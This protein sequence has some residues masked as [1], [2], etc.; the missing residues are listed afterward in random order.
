MLQVLEGIG[1]RER[2]ASCNIQSFIHHNFER[3]SSIP[4]FHSAHSIPSLCGTH[5]H[6]SST[7]PPN[8]LERT[9][10]NTVP[11]YSDPSVRPS[12]RSE[13]CSPSLTHFTTLP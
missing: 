7:H 11:E 4:D 5:F 8:V 12:P 6:T 9:G 2:E 3:G 10:P 13:P 1:P